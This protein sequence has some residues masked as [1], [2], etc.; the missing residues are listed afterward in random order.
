MTDREDGPDAP[1]SLQPADD[2]FTRVEK[3]VRW[4][5]WIGLAAAIVWVFADLM[6]KH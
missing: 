4:A 2:R 5:F 3:I 6:I 1:A